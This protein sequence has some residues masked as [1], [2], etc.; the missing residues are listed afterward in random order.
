MNCIKCPILEE[1][2][3]AKMTT[4]SVY[5]QGI[6]LPLRAEPLDREECP[7]LAAIAQAKVRELGE[8]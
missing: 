8:T 7:L 2:G 3:A 4:E 6:T 5:P 1:C